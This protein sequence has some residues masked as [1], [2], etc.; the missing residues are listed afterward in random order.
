M[1]ELRTKAVLIALLLL[2]LVLTA[3][4][5]LA[6]TSWITRTPPLAMLVVLAVTAVHVLSD[7]KTTR[8]GP[9]GNPRT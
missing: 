4:G 9:W 1:M 7:R 2:A 6:A 8:S 5:T 3:V